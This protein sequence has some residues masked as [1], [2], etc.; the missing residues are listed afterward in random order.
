MCSESRVNKFLSEYYVLWTHRKL[1]TFWTHKTCS[2]YSITL[3]K[4]EICKTSR[5]FDTFRC[6]QDDLYDYENYN[7]FLW[8]LSCPGNGIIKPLSGNPRNVKRD[9]NIVRIGRFWRIQHVLTQKICEI[10]WV[11]IQNYQNE[12]SGCQLIL[13]LNVV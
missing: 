7:L 4:S 12:N 1:L 13:N 8:K 6:I 2:T 11:I 9:F 10:S 3:N 5:Y